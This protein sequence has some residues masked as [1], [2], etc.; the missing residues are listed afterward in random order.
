V[1]FFDY[2]FVGDNFNLIMAFETGD[3]VNYNLAQ[4]LFLLYREFTYGRHSGIAEFLIDGSHQIRKSGL[5]TADAGRTGI[6]AQVYPMIP[7]P[8]R[9]IGVCNRPLASQLIQAARFAEL[10]GKFS[11]QI[12]GRGL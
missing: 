10:S 3:R 11:L 6:D 4:F 7:L 9:T 12:A 2:S 1:G 5:A 8:Q